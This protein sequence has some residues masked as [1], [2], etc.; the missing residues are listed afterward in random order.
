MS[1]ARTVLTV[2]A[3]VVVLPLALR[4][5]ESGSARASLLPTRAEGKA[6]VAIPS[7][8][9][10]PGGDD[11]GQRASE[12]RAVLHCPGHASRATMFV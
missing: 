6:H 4:A 1:G 2:M 11:E 10:K 9:T 12:M 3:A 7:D 5:R 8:S